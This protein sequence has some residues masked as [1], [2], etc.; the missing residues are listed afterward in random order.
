MEQLQQ[1]DVLLECYI[2]N[3]LGAYFA[4]KWLQV[5]GICSSKMRLFISKAFLL[6]GPLGVSFQRR[7][8]YRYIQ[9]CHLAKGDN[10]RSSSLHIPLC[11]EMLIFK[12][13]S[14]LGAK[15]YSVENTP[16]NYT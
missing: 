12:P 6:S 7:F 14:S 13:K 10:L 3:D 5:L 2:K 15:A 16:L 8:C 1:G 9:H 4:P 11:Q